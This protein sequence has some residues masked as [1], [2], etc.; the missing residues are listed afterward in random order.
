MLDVLAPAIDAPVTFKLPVIVTAP[1]FIVLPVSVF[2][3]PFGAI[4]PTT[5]P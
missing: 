5:L 4:L 1:P 3:E 2:G